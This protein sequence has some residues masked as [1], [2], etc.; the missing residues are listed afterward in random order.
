VHLTPAAPWTRSQL[1]GAMRL[2]AKQPSEALR[3]ACC[4]EPAYVA[5][6]S[7]ATGKRKRTTART[8]RAIGAFAGSSV[9]H[10]FGLAASARS[11]CRPA[12]AQGSCARQRPFAVL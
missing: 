4:V 5:H 7:A 8:P 12:R 1:L 11:A 10:V 6:A 9:G 3:L 2:A